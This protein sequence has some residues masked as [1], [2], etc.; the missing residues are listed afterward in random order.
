MEVGPA[1]LG[2]EYDLVTASEL[3][4]EFLAHVR[5]LKPEDS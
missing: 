2:G 1:N 4:D 3:E 5:S